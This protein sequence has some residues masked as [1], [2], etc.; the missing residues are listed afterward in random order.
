MSGPFGAIEFAATGASMAS[1]WMDVLGH[2]LANVNTTTPTDGEPFRAKYLVVKE[3]SL[4]QGVD[5]AEI[6]SVSG[7]AP[8]LYDPDNPMA[9][10]DGLV[11]GALIDVAGQMSDMI[12][13]SRHYQLNLQV[14]RTA[15]EAYQA[16][17]G[18]GR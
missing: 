18:I 16:A 17:L 14:V 11:Q 7:D 3:N 2:N 1:T 8:L 9:D 6:V 12:I 10:E 15:E 4:S 5:M 13:A